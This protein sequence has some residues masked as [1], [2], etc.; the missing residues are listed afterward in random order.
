MS[1]VM[2]LLFCWNI[3]CEA[4]VIRAVHIRVVMIIA[5]SGNP[6]STGY[7]PMGSAYDVA[8][9]RARTRYPGLFRNLSVTRH[10]VAG[11]NL[12]CEE[13]AAETTIALG[14]L[15]LNR[16]DPDGIERPP[17]EPAVPNG[18][19]RER[20]FQV[21]LSPGCGLQETTLG[22]FAREEDI[23]VIASATSL[24]LLNDKRRFPTVL[25]FSGGSFNN[26]ALAVV[27]MLQRFGW[28][29][30][31]LVCDSNPGTGVMVE[32]ACGALR[33][34][35]ASARTVNTVP[36]LFNSV[37][38][39]TE[40]ITSMLRECDNHSSV[41]VLAS[42][43]PR[44]YIAILET[45]F[46]MGMADGD[47]AFIVLPLSGNA[48]FKEIVSDLAV[49]KQLSRSV[50]AILPFTFAL[51]FDFINWTAVSRDMEQIAERS[52]AAYN[53]TIPP[54]LRQS[55]LMLTGFETASVLC[56]ASDLSPVQCA[57][58]CA[59]APV[60]CMFYNVPK[61]RYRRV[62]RN[63]SVFL[64]QIYSLL[65]FKMLHENLEHLWNMSGV[66]FAKQFY[67][68][69]FPLPSR[70]LAVNAIGGRISQVYTH[71]F[72]NQ[73]DTFQTV[74]LLNLETKNLS[75]VNGT[76]MRWYG[77]VF[78]PSDQPPRFRQGVGR[79]TVIAV[80]ATTAIAVVLLAAFALFG[81]RIYRSEADISFWLLDG[82]SLRS[83]RRPPGTG[84][85]SWIGS[86]TYIFT[87]IPGGRP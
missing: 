51:A 64:T 66:G 38:N 19:R 2:F 33:Q 65:Y 22:D 83:S 15:L 48:Q 69:V 43:D 76:V 79:L 18:V 87:Y 47:H 1:A 29:T 37:A 52:Q 71:Q 14:Q 8:L 44:V 9:D 36:V 5:G 3:L 77:S 45:A 39:S 73:T 75:A 28:R 55:P 10:F 26:V 4:V 74:L 84:N 40:R 50:K 21:V 82:E 68:R 11:S 6:R 49:Q 42:V 20:E 80:A 24:A 46:Q 81:W 34:V 58:Q 31:N 60:Q 54:E 86:G 78:P 12:T 13:A 23:A 57:V 61:S 53:L 62:V 30:F 70:D 16:M 7:E 27:A 17:S 25:P 35:I 56:Q 85:L 72:D 41:T 32:A 63:L 59:S 67:N